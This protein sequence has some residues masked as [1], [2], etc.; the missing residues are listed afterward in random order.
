MA[1]V[2]RGPSKEPLI[3][4]YRPPITIRQASLP[5]AASNAA[6]MSLVSSANIVTARPPETATPEYPEPRGTRQ[7]S[8]GAPDPEAKRLSRLALPSWLGPRRPGHSA[9]AGDD[10]AAQQSAAIRGRRTRPRSLD[11]EAPLARGRSLQ[12]RA[13]PGWQR[14]DPFWNGCVLPGNS[15]IPPRG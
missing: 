4:L 2:E 9:A 7:R 5:V 12:L 15:R 1:G 11:M 8:V 13:R 6:R 14:R 10:R 3:P